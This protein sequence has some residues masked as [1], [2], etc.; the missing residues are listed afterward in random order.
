M[1]EY[2]NYSQAEKSIIDLSDITNEASKKKEQ[3]NKIA[4]SKNSNEGF[5]YS[6]ND[7]L[8]NFFVHS[9]QPAMNM[10][11]GSMG[12]GGMGNVGGGYNPGMMGANPNMRVGGGM[13]PMGGMN[14]GGM[15]QGGMGMNMGYGQNMGGMNA[16]FNP[17]M[18]QMGGNM[19]QGFGSKFIS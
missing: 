4:A 16:N 11:M 3:Q 8:D 19:Q 15:A 14:M 10:G 17:M 5:L 1:K 9:N 7:D 13:Q 6:T 2:K 18:G 12:M